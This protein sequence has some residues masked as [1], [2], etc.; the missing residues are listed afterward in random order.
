MTIRVMG[1]VGQGGVWAPAGSR[2]AIEKT[3]AVMNVSRLLR[4]NGDFMMR[5]CVGFSK[6]AH[7]KQ[8]SVSRAC[9][10]GLINYK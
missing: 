10:R 8:I 5:A 7:L 9:S 2:Q 6:L 4:G 1:L 3:T